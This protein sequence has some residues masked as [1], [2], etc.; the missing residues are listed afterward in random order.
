MDLLSLRNELD[1]IDAQIV[2]L[3]EKRMLICAQVAEYKIATGK[4]VLDRQRE[5]EKLAKV[6]SL[7]HNEFNSQGVE[8]LFE[9]IMS[10]SRKL[11]YK[12]MAEQGITEKSDIE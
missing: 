9:Q 7:T 5:L 4:K 10:S 8:E 11:Q 1:E 3:Y 12:M 2:E 6:K